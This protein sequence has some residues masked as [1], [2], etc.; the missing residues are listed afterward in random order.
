MT[1]VDPLVRVNG[2]PLWSSEMVHGSLP[3]QAAPA[4]ENDSVV[5][6]PLVTVDCPA[7]KLEITGVART[8]TVCRVVVP[9]ALV[10]DSI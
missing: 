10:T 8:V 1:A 2:V 9:P 3:V 7:W 6:W 5:P 4:K